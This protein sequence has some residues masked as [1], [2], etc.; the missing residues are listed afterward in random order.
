MAV[1]PDWRGPGL[2]TRLGRAFLTAMRDRG[3]GLVKAA[4]GVTNDPALATC[5]N[6]GFVSEGAIEVHA[7]EPSE[8]LVWRG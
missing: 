1:A 7:G 4:V 5:R 3:V 8:I 6:I 2:G